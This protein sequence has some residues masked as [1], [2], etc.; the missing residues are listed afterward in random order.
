M[1]E[2]SSMVQNQK[3]RRSTWLTCSVVSGS[4]T[5]KGSWR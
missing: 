2:G 1:V 5:T 3:L 4:T